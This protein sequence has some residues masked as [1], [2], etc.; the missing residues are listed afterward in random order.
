MY[1]KKCG[2]ESQKDSIF[3]KDCGARLQDDADIN[4]ET[5]QRQEN[6]DYES[7]HDAQDNHRWMYEF[8][9]WKNPT[10]FISGMKIMLIAC[11][12]PALFMFFLTLIDGDGFIEALKVAFSLSLIGAGILTVLLAAAYA[13]IA[14][15]YKGKYYVLFKMDKKGI[16]HI[17]LKKQYSKA[18]ALGLLSL[19]MGLAGGSLST[20]GAGL[21]SASRQSQYSKF[22]NVK[23][24]KIKEKRSV[25]YL[26]EPFVKN[27]IYAYPENFHHIKDYIIAQCPKDVKITY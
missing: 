17:Q 1:C 19:L 26:N 23:S 16:H 22:S 24:I 4:S 13:L 21:M 14:L 6:G 9:L 11:C 10:I 3:C 8:S 2:T 18:Q 5:G 27:Q 25:I 20:A 12:I 15:L 7:F